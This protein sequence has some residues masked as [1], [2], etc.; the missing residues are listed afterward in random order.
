MTDPSSPISSET[1]KTQR[2][3][4]EYMTVREG[5]YYFKRKVPA[6]V[7]PLLTPS[8]KQIWKSLKTSVFEEAA[9]KLQ[10]H[11]DQFDEMVAE[12]RGLGSTR[13]AKSGKP[14]GEGTTK[15]LQAEHIPALLAR[16]RFM[17]LETDDQERSVEGWTADKL[18]RRAARQERL[19]LMEEGLEQ[20]KELAADADYSE[21][22]DVVQ[23]IL[24][25][26][27][28]IAPPNSPLRTE[29]AKKLLHQ[30]IEL[31]KMQRDRLLG[32]EHPTPEHVPVAPRALPTLLDL[33]KA[34]RPSQSNHRTVNTYLHFVE[35]FEAFNGALPVVAINDSHVDGYKRLLT[36]EGVSRETVRNHL[37]GIATLLRAARKTHDVSA[38]EAAFNDVSL[39]DVPERDSDEDRRAY[40]MHELRTLFTSKLYTDGYRPKGQSKE[41]AYWAPLI[42]PFVAGRLEEV[43]QLLVDDIQCVNGHWLIRIADLDGDQNLKSKTSYRFVPIHQELVR[44]GFLSYAAEMKLKGHKRLFPSLTN[45]NVHER[46]GGSLGKW[47]GR[48]LDS[49]GLSDPR[50]DYHSFR[51]LFK[52]RCHQSGIDNEVRDALTGHWLHQN[53]ASRGYMRSADRQ[54]PLP[55]L[56]DA[57][58]KLRYDELDLSHLYI[59]EP[60]R[61]TEALR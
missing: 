3:L 12:A 4:P 45:D 57:M 15:Y 55:E 47:Y 24:T 6:D 10:V 59:V 20:F 5:K 40:E 49:I 39:S 54:Y 7:V 35:R 42:G 11:I 26:E 53:P 27:Q 9:V 22:L 51:F 36:K 19:A 2:Q 37:S 52:Q 14:R 34:W 28:L 21:H 29:L 31:L 43:A 23:L 32:E 61:G 50:L 46:F 44:C 33:H 18:T 17:V 8:K 60:M 13:R 56:V 38:A 16:H 41:A 25:E 30:D 58:H 48:Y 1:L